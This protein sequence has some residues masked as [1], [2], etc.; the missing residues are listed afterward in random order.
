M[1]DK[2]KPYRHIQTEED[3]RIKGWSETPVAG[4]TIDTEGMELA[5]APEDAIYAAYYDAEE[6]TLEWRKVAEFADLP[7][8]ESER[9]ESKLDYLMAQE[10]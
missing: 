8:T 6:H 4:V 2:N 1:Y 5:D 3:G 9:I 10:G 7:L